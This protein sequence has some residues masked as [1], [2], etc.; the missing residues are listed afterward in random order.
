MVLLP[1][2]LILFLYRRPD[3]LM[4]IPGVDVLPQTEDINAHGDVIHFL[5][6]VDQ[7][8]SATVQFR[9]VHLTASRL[10]VVFASVASLRPATKFNWRCRAEN[11]ERVIDC[12]QT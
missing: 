5:T 10:A 6:T 1:V 4:L 7:E 12:M 11:V 3:E 9:S 8:K 2:S